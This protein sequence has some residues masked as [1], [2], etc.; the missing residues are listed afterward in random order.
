MPVDVETLLAAFDVEH[1]AHI[2]I[3]ADDTCEVY[4]HGET[5]FR[6][7]HGKIAAERTGYSVAALS[8]TALPDGSGETT[9]NGFTCTGLTR[10]DTTWFISNAGGTPGGLEADREPSIVLTSAA[11][12]GVKTGEI[13]LLPLYPDCRSA[14]GIAIRA[15]DDTLWVA[16]TI[17]NPPSV[18]HMTKAGVPLSGDMTDFPSWRPNA[19]SDDPW[20]DELI[21]GQEGGTAIEWRSYA[22]GSVTKTLTSPVTIDHLF[23]YSE[24]LLLV[25]TD[26]TPDGKITV[27]DATT[28]AA[29][30]TITL[31][32]SDAIEGVYA[33]WSEGVMSVYIANDGYFHEKPSGLNSVLSYEL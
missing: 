17:D 2:M 30:G 22:D 26:G 33:S 20:R 28:G 25:T 32:G 1:A 15:A 3:A 27:V 14:Q 7:P 5:M 18:R 13:L 31:Q 4:R 16:L 19:L 12:F 10:D 23:L 11:S 8:D 24:N 6:P 29:L 9:G 21:V